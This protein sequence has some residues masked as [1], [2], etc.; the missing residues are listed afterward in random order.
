MTGHL[1]VLV[2]QAHELVRCGGV[3]WTHHHR[4]GAHGGVPYQLSH[5]LARCTRR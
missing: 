4:A 1:L 5:A 2:H 3:H